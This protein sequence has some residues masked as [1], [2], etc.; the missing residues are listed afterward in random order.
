[1]AA[2]LG[3]GSNLPSVPFATVT[4]QDARCHAAVTSSPT[5]GG[6][7]GLAILTVTGSTRLPYDATLD[8]ILNGEMRTLAGSSADKCWTLW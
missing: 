5:G 7:D 1:M 8:A 3:S 6:R 4:K 2:S